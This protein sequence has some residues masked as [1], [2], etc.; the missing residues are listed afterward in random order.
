MLIELDRPSPIASHWKKH[1]HIFF[2][3]DGSQAY[4]CLDDLTGLLH[5]VED[6]DA[7]IFEFGVC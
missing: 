4:T 7:G 2:H 5:L 3:M 1:F 6:G